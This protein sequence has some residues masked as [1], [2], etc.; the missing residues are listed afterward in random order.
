[1]NTKTFYITTTLPYVN[2]K[3]HIGFATEILRADILARH[4]RILLGDENVLTGK[5]FLTDPRKLFYFKIS[6]LGKLVT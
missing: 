2:G 1:M 3:P 4:K 6:I 5:W